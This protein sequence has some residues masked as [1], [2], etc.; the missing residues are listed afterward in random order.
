MAAHLHGDVDLFAAAAVGQTTS[1]TPGDEPAAVIDAVA[2]ETAV[3]TLLNQGR[4]GRVDGRL[5]SCWL[6]LPGGGWVLHHH[7]DL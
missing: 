5:E 3:R 2:A 7:I 6:R 1:S 4:S